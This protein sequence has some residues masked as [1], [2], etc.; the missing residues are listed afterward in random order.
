MRMTRISMA[1]AIACL[2]WSR[3][4]A[5]QSGRHVA[6]V[7]GNSAY[8]ATS[9]LKNP[10][11]DAREMASVFHAL[12]FRKVRLL[13]DADEAQ[14]LRAFN[15]FADL[16]HG[17]DVGVVFYSG[18]GM[19]LDGNN[20]LIPIDARLQDERR[21]RSQSISLD[22]VRDAAAGAHFSMVILDACRNHIF[23]TMSRSGARG[24]API[25]VAAR[26]TGQMLVY[27]T[28]PGRIALDGT[29]DLSPFTE[30]LAARL[31][32]TPEMDVRIWPSLL[33]LPDGQ[34]PYYE[35][36]SGLTEAHVSLLA[37]DETGPQPPPI[38]PS[39]KLGSGSMA[40]P[41]PA[42]APLPKAP[43]LLEKPVPEIV[44]PHLMAVTNVAFSPN[45][46]RLL[47]GSVRGAQ[48]WDPRAGVQLW[49]RDRIGDAR[50]IASL[51]FDP[52][53]GRFAI[54]GDYW[55]GYAQI[56]D[57]ETGE[58]LKT[59]NLGSYVGDLAFSPDGRK[60]AV[61]DSSGR[62][63]IWDADSDAELLKFSHGN[64]VNDVA[65]SPDGG[66]IITGSN[67]K[68]AVIRDAET[69]A[70]I[71]VLQHEDAVSR[72]AFS[73]DG[74]RIATGSVDGKLRIWEANSEA[75]P[76]ILAQRGPILSLA[77]SPDGGLIAIGD[78][79]GQ[80]RI[81]D[82]RTGASLMSIPHDGA[83]LSVA[84]SPDGR[85]LATG[86]Q[87]YLAQIWEIATP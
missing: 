58:V 9:P 25:S 52:T 86:S 10:G 3:E 60:I 64:A 59:I 87:D 19:E 11:N 57:V 1:L 84:F 17:A 30:A 44:L 65:F 55:G 35:G 5:A 29:G 83:V 2:L 13:L 82:A 12:G 40:A 62:V 38:A 43:R 6:L 46:A 23:P 67:D 72:V 42:A 47:T 79:G 28:A 31:R 53:G 18:H 14:M 56:R 21:G 7:I 27:S 45:G 75:E 68:T 20:H 77:F 8:T 34:E 70:Q 15:E 81:W 41:P 71:R 69:G 37:P 26:K 22:L 54:S 78:R 4:A 48:L 50:D 24:L 33:R 32:A 66:R 63:M 36:V 39:A 85:R 51:V 80:A 73:P 61:G 49:V 76:R 74:G 16:A